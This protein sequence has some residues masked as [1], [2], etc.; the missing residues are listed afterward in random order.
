MK[1]VNHNTV[2]LSL[3]YSF[4]ACRE[5]VNNLKIKVHTHT[6][7]LDQERILLSQLGHSVRIITKMLDILKLNKWNKRM[8]ILCS[9]D[10]KLP[11]TYTVCV[12]AAILGKVMERETVDDYVKFSLNIQ[13]VFKRSRDSR[14][15]R[16]NTFLWVPL[17]DLACKC[18]KIKTNKWV[19]VV[20]WTLDLDSRP[21]VF[22]RAW[23]AP[24]PSCGSLSR[25]W[26]AN[27]PITKP[28]SGATL[29]IF[30]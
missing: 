27:V 14:L 30:P 2:K 5:V 22:K 21:S 25:T 15:R 10:C 19:L 11:S 23:G 6:Y 20:L 4:E 29:K 9:I 1:C 12:V 7:Q 28:T 17:K 26:P 18:P 16:T 8:A 24:T 13:S 3:D